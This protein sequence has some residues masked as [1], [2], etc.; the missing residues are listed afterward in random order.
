M[1]SRKNVSSEEWMLHPLEV[2]IVLEVFGRAQVDLFASED[3]S[4]CPIFLQ[5]AQMP[6][7]TNGPA[8]SSVLSP[9]SL[10]CRRHSDESGK[11]GTSLF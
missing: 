6:W 11:N 9:Q 1:L 3:N 5:R 8:F 2:Q 4:H 7:P 10:C